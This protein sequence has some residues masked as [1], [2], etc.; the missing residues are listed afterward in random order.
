M[1][2]N[3]MSPAELHD[4]VRDGLNSGDLEGL[5]GLY[6]PDAVLMT[7]EGPPMV[8]TAAIREGYATVLSFGG[9][10]TLATRHAVECGELALLSNEYTFTAPGY[11]A[12]WTTSEV[13]RRQPDGSWRYVIDNPYA[14]P[15]TP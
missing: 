1:T 9:S 11:E 2:G 12:S 8:G 3:A 15:V 7:E 10:I 14:A 4:R 5:V 13:A 6:E